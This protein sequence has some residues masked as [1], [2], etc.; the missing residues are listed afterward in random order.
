MQGHIS[1]VLLPIVYNAIV[2]KEKEYNEESKERQAKCKDLPWL[3]RFFVEVKSPP[4]SLPPS[5][6]LAST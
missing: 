5:T 4:P 1:I 6:T 3:S 2:A